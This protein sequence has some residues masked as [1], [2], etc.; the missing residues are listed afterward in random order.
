M[1]YTAEANYR[2]TPHSIS[3]TADLGLR[4]PWFL[5]QELLMQ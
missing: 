2:Q 5:V 3:A 1:Y 4:Q